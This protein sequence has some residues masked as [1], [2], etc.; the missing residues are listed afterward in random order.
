MREVF[1]RAWRNFRDN[2]PLAGIEK[3]IVDVA[4]RHP[5]YQAILENPDTYQEQ[6]YRPEMHETNPFLH[7]GL[8]LA[9]HEQLTTDRPP[10]VL[11]VYK[12]LLT[13][14]ND[15]H[16]VEHHMMDCLA[17]ALWRTQHEG[18]QPSE[19]D[20]LACLKRQAGYN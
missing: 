7:M 15:P 16:A 17:E 13:R 10:G 11:A 2:C 20:Y 9:I 4:L 19:D 12:A 6:D 18:A 5:E 3:V 14:H 8:H 1:F